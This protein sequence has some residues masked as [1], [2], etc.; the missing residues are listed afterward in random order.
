MVDGPGMTEVRQCGIS[1]HREAWTL[2]QLYKDLSKGI[3]LNCP[4]CFLFFAKTSFEGNSGITDIWVLSDG[5]ECIAI[6]WDITNTDFECD[7]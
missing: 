6:E 3:Y 4:N 7:L 5:W 1:N 2:G